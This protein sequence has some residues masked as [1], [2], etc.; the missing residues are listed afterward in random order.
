M[1]GQGS[2][3]TIARTLT[4]GHNGL[5]SQ[6]RS[7]FFELYFQRVRAEFAKASSVRVHWDGSTHDGFDVQL[8]LALTGRDLQ[9]AAVLKPEV[10]TLNSEFHYLLLIGIAFVSLGF[11]CMVL[12]RNRIQIQ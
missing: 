7:A 3:E 12:R 5:A 4:P 10:P 6:A 8:G 2:S 1:K 11:R 9:L